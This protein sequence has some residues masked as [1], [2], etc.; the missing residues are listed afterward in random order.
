MTNVG[1]YPGKV[2]LYQHCTVHYFG[3]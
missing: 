1:G 3:A 2:D